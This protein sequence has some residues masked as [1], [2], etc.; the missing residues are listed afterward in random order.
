MS[1]P[2]LEVADIMRA[3]AGR[4]IERSLFPVNS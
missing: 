4:F 1:Q 2:L 3:F